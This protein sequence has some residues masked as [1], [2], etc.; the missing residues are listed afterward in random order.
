MEHGES[1][2]EEINKLLKTGR[3]GDFEALTAL[4]KV[5]CPFEA[6]GMIHQEIRHSHY[7]TY[8][9]DPKRPHGFGDTMLQGFLGLIADA[10]TIDLGF[11]KQDLHSWDQAEA[12]IRREWRD[13]DLLI[14]L[15]TPNGKSEG[16]VVAVELKINA[17]ESE[18]QLAKYQAIVEG[19]YKGW[20]Q[21]FVF[22]T[23]NNEQPSEANK[24][25]W[26]PLALEAMIDCLEKVAKDQSFT[27][28]SAYL[29]LA[30]EA[31]L[32]RHHLRNS[33]LEELT[34]K[35]WAK[36]K[37]ALDILYEYKP[38][39]LGDLQAELLTNQE[40]IIERINAKLKTVDMPTVELVRKKSS[41]GRIRFGVKK[42]TEYDK[43]DAGADDW[44]MFIEI[45]KNGDTLVT[46]LVMGPSDSVFWENVYQGI[47][48]GSRTVDGIFLE[49]SGLQVKKRTWEHLST[50]VI[51]EIDSKNGE[52]GGAV[53]LEKLADDSIKAFVTHWGEILPKYDNLIKEMWEEK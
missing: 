12:V 34:R 14:E 46:A 47:F 33:E 23:K 1:S 49:N 11:S 9:L 51:V 17:K 7:L 40:R 6:I 32:R 5:F 44:R 20:T 4:T 25:T 19:Q 43:L 27:G 28:P 48:K 15:P 41:R 22:L 36:H 18:R 35:V 29:F 39:F 13:I 37:E 30:Y 52:V 26:M 21:V 2:V 10:K 50:T 3:E 42:W 8:I 24:E 31:M 38:N 45:Y 53:N 16:L